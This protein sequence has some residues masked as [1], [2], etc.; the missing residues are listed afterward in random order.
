MGRIAA[1][2]HR[3][4]ENFA[5]QLDQLAGRVGEYHFD[6]GYGDILKVA[7][8]LEERLLTGVF[9]IV[10]G[11]LGLPGQATRG[12]VAELYHRG[13]T[14]GNHTM[15]HVLMPRVPEPVQVAE[16]EAGQVAICDIIGIKPD[17]FA[18]PYGQAGDVHIGV[19][20][21]GIQA[22]EV[23]APRNMRGW[24]IHKAVQRLR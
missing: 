20:P 23:F 1:L 5:E 22:D 14:I 12:D 2:W 6:D 24:E 11:W 13:H 18:W 17:R 4:P 19:T 7:D 21:R 9:Y 15:H 10:P 3:V 8:M 16:W